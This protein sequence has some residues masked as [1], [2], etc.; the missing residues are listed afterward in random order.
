MQYPSLKSILSSTPEEAAEQAIRDYCGWHVTPAVEET[1]VV[2]GNGQKK[3][4]LPSRKINDVLTVEVDGEPVEVRWSADG[5]ITRVDGRF[6]DRERAIT[7]TINHGLEHGSAVIDQVIGNIVSRARMSPAGNIVSQRAGTQSVTF[8]S[9][10][11][12]VT[13]YGLLQSEKDLL[14]PYK[15]NWG[16]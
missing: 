13:G 3:I 10:G 12:E 1:L 14:A 5:W 4:L 6:P 11:G 9:S 16:P 2:D 7:V 8:A 15:L